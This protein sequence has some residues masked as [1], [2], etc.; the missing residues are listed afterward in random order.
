MAKIERFYDTFQ[1][2]HYDVYVD[3]DRAKKTIVGETTITGTATQSEISVN[4]K[5]L[6]I[7][8]VIADGKPVE[9]KT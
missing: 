3:V 2:E 7:D 6:V 9:F 5:Y 1:P 8:E 4:Q